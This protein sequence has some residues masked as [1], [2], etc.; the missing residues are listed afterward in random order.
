MK[1]IDC[2]NSDADGL[3]ALHQLRLAEPTDSELITGVKRDIQL[4]ERV[5]HHRDCEFTVLDI[6]LDHNRD[7]LTQLLEQGNRIRWFDHHFPGAIPES[8]LLHTTIETNPEVCTS[9]LV[10]QQLDGKFREWPLTAAFGDNLH[11]SAQRLAEE[12]GLDAKQQF[13]IRELG[14]LLNY[15][16]YGETVADLHFPP[17]QLYRHLQP[18]ETSWSFIHESTALPQLREGHREDQS[19]ARALSPEVE[20]SAGR[21]F[22]LPNE[23]WCRRVVGV[24]SNRMARERPELAHAVFVKT[25]RGT[26]VV[27]VRAPLERPQ[28]ADTLCRKFDGGGRSGAAG[29]NALPDAEV[30]RFLRAFAACFAVGTQ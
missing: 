29:I 24:F 13:Q 14:E 12:A 16:G 18:H 2:F 9:I 30:D 23:P 17:D 25:G 6:S 8:P 11:G 3:C 10:D 4:L 1:R 20:T 28:G 15:N 27:S 5:K 22:R 26:F 21:V 19:K 7:A